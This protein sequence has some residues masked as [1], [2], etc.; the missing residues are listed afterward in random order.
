MRT[1]AVSMVI[2]AN[3]SF[4]FPNSFDVTYRLRHDGFDLNDVAAVYHTSQKNK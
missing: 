2:I 1:F 3:F 4:I